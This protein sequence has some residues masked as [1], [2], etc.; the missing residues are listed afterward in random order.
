M[1]FSHFSKKSPRFRPLISFLHTTP[2]WFFLNAFT[3]D[4]EFFFFFQGGIGRDIKEMD[5][6]EKGKLT[7]LGNEIATVIVKLKN[8]LKQRISSS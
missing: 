3:L 5:E 2:E 1:Y 6:C 7:D 8:L 4:V